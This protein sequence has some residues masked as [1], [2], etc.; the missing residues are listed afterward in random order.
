M[1][2]Y[3]HNADVESLKVALEHCIS[4]RLAVLHPDGWRCTS[5]TCRPP[6]MMWCF[7][8]SSPLHL[9]W[10]SMDRECGMKVVWNLS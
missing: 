8:R 9:P 4:S 1:F 2:L 7:L 3:H 6:P 5:R 10:F